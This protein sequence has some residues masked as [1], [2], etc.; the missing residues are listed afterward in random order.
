MLLHEPLDRT[1][2]LDCSQTIT[3]LSDAISCLG[4]EVVLIEADEDAYER[5]R[6]SGVGLVFN[7]AEGIR[8]ED[9]E[10][11]IPA[12][13]EMLGI[14]YT[15]SGPLTLAI[16][17]NKARTKEILSWHGIPT[18]AFQV[19]TS[20]QESLSGTLGYPLIVKLLHEGSSM[21]LSYDS[22]VESEEALRR[23]VRYLR[24][25]YDQPVL[26]EQFIEGR[27]FTVPVTGNS[28][29]QALP[30][31]EVVFQGPRPITL[32][33]PD[34]AVIRMLARAQGQRI[35]AGEPF[36]LSDDRRFARLQTDTG[37]E[38]EVPVT[39]SRSICPANVCRSLA[40][41]IRVTA[42]RA[43][44]ALECRDWC[45]IDMRVGADQ[46]PQVLELN[47]IAGID[48]SYWFPRS[49]MAA[50]MRYAELIGV[51]IDAARQRYRI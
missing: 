25:T 48:S 11:Q 47:P 2:E 20:P 24:E 13:L 12:M 38:L 9:R 49:A 15:G 33:Q 51:I 5:L 17:L 40:E 28:P 6:A 39:L 42:L 19:W 16:C 23:R 50:G 7:I 46:V 22:V 29:A 43:Y 26:V 3:A 8:G 44:R 10:A 18:P 27:E 34:D 21:G 37:A 45:R 30:A 14:P 41:A 36:K 1:A 32:F 31:I 35:V 4:H